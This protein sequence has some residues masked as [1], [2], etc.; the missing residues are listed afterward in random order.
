MGRY[1][2]RPRRRRRAAAAAL[3]IGASLCI[4]ANGCLSGSHEAAPPNILVVVT[5]DQPTGMVQRMPFLTNVP[6]VTRFESYYDNNP[7]CCPTRATLL[8]GLYSHHTDVE[9]NLVADRFDDSSTLATWLNARGY[10]TG[11]FGKYL[12]DYPWDKGRT[13][14]PPGW[15]AWAAFA[16]DAAYYDYTLASPNGRRQYGHRPRDYSTDVLAR[17]TSA[18]IRDAEQ[19]FFAYFAPFGPHAPRTPAPRDRAAYSSEPVSLPANF[20]RVAATAPRWWRKRPPLNR[21]EMREATRSQWRTLLSVDDAIK[22]FF[23]L[24]R[25]AGELD[26]TIVIVVSDNGY[27]LGSHRNPWKDCPYEECVHLPLLVRWPDRTTVPKVKALTA[28]I[29]IAP[30]IAE[31]AGAT[32][33]PSPDGTSLVPLIT[34]ESSSVQR[35]V[36]LRHVHYPRTAPSFWGIR[37]ERWMYALYETG[38]RELYNVIRDRFELHNLAGHRAYESVERELSERMKVLRR[39]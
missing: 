19:P 20:N 21:R 34:G 16:G 35:P 31:M 29:D 36:L 23:L 24:M 4:F 1:R 38:E 13:Y 3:L 11:L 8:T 12:N 17:L 10:E 14:L 37:T 33:S 22:R 28:A 15:D 25:D 32:A 18:F 5:D 6:G 26:S 2:R 39:G 27:S 7:L 9:T 30:T